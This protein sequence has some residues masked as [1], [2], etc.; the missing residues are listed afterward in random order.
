MESIAAPGG[1]GN[2]YSTSMAPGPVLTNSWSMFTE[3]T[4]SRTDIRTW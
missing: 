1:T 2:K 3:A 4:W